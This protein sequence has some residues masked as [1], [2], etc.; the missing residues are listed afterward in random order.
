MTIAEYLIECPNDLKFLR[1]KR[2]IEVKPL[3]TIK[4]MN[5]KLSEIR[6]TERQSLEM[7]ALQNK[8]AGRLHGWLI[9]SGPPAG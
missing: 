3:Y 5:L 9:R 7:T 1:S 2:R 6:E 8:M 4:E